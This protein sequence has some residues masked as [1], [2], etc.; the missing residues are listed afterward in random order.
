MQIVFLTV[1][2]DDTKVSAWASRELA[3]AERYRLLHT[4]NRE[5]SEAMEIML[6]ARIARLRADIRELSKDHDDDH[7]EQ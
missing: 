1:D 4:R 3:E 5:Y 7:P 2:F 6:I